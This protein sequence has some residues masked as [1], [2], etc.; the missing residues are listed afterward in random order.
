MGSEPHSGHRGS[1][2]HRVGDGLAMVPLLVEAS[3]VRARLT[4]RVR[5]YHEC[6][7]IPLPQVPFAIRKQPPSSC[8]AR[9][10]PRSNL[11]SKSMELRLSL[12]I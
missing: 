10:R 7:Y 1:L 6:L 5:L 8:A 11:W 3:G 12:A 2:T 9:G 4:Q